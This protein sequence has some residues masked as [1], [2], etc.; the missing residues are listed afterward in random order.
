MRIAE[1]LRSKGATVTTVAP[2][3]TVASLL[4]V[5]AEHNIGAVV[6]SPDG[7]RLAGIV[8]ERDVVRHLHSRGAE[9]LHT[10]VSAIMTA[11]VRTCALDDQVDGLRNIMTEHRVRH[12]PVVV[13]DRLVGLVS[14]GD[15]VKSAISE[16]TT[17]HQHL[18]EYVQGR[19]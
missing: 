1:I 19:Y 13:G 6:V 9:L 7:I 3:T 11:D 10:P 12:L 8:T 17:E 16:L 4:G 18:V 14:I 2:G 5:L 15:V